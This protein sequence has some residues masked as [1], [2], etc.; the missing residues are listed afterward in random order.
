MLGGF[1]LF[2]LVAGIWY[3]PMYMLHGQAF[4]DVFLGGHNVMRATVSEH[5]EY[6][7]WYYY[8]VVFL[9]G[10]FPWV[11]A[12]IPAL[13]KGGG[14]AGGWLWMRIPVSCWCGP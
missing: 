11:L 13:V 6:N 14:E 8:L 10:F 12:A 1:V 4:I 5:P 2:G 3:V 7:V 9:L